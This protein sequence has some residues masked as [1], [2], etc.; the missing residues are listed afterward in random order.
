LELGVGTGRTLLPLARDGYKVVGVDMAPRMLARCRA[1]AQHLSAVAQARIELHQADFRA[2]RLGR[3]FPLVICPFNAFMHL[4]RRADVEQFLAT[5]RAHLLPSGR[6]A[7]DVLNPDLAWLS[8]D[9]K[10]RW[11]RTRFRHPTSRRWMIYSTSLRYDA[12]MQIAFMRIYY[13][14]ER[15]GRESVVRLAHRQF[16]PRELAALLYYNG[17]VIE[18]HDGDFDG[19]P[20]SATS[21]TQV[22]ECHLRRKK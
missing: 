7:F 2:V 14:A 15:G 19:A 4:Y 9:P 17:F 20:L 22:L 21:D 18:R 10:R 3:R 16:F 1:R 8:R 6:F 12:A 11:A 13:Q 5:V